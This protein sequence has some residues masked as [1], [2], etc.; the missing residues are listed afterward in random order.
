[1]Q[2]LPSG[3]DRII[4]QG[5]FSGFT[6]QELFDHWVTPSLLTQWWPEEAEVMPGMGGNYCFRWPTMGWELKGEYK[7][8]TPGERLIFTWQWSHEPVELE[9]L[10]VTVDFDPALEGGSVMTITQGMY[11]ESPAHQQDRQGHV[12]GWIH[13]GM[14]LAGLRQSTG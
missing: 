7:D 1:M 6:Q 13:F 4:V 9:P 10:R 14:V 8:F 3:N 11:G 2:Q 12:E 5:H